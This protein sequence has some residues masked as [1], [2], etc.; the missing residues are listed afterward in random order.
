MTTRIININKPTGIS[1]HGRNLFDKG[2]NKRIKSEKNNLKLFNIL[3]FGLLFCIIKS[4]YNR[5][6]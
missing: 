1:N 3:L 5:Q 2:V 6:K 4:L